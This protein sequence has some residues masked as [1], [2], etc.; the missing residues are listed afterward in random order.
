MCGVHT[1]RFRDH[2]CSAQEASGQAT[3]H[4]STASHFL[5]PSFLPASF[6]AHLR[7]SMPGDPARERT[8][9]L[10]SVHNIRPSIGAEP[11][12]TC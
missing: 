12:Q 5:T 1:V 7:A 9:N 11:G 3:A 6:I 10:H 8:R 2:L 4:R